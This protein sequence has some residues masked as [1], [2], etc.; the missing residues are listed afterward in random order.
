[1]NLPKKMI[2]FQNSGQFFANKTH[3][4]NEVFFWKLIFF[5]QQLFPSG[6]PAGTI[7]TQSLHQS[8]SMFFTMLTDDTPE[9]KNA[10][11]IQDPHQDYYHCHVCFFFQFSLF[12]IY[13]D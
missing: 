1:V 10:P 11:L 12:F 2:S 8:P 9:L 5:Y 3:F 4:L 13:S 6:Y 7:L